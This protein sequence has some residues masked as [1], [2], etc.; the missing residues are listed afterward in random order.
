MLV[1]LGG[2]DHWSPLSTDR[3]DWTEMS[4]WEALGLFILIG[5]LAFAVVAGDGPIVYGVLVV[6]SLA[7]IYD[8][9]TDW[10]QI[11]LI[12]D[13]APETI[14]SV[15]VGRT[16]VHGTCKPLERPLPRP[17]SEEPCVLSYW[18]VE[19]YND[20]W[21][22]LGT[23]VRYVPF[24]V[25]DVTG[26]IEVDPPVDA[27]PKMSEQ[28]STELTVGS[29]VGVLSQEPEPVVAFLQTVDDISV[30]DSGMLSSR[31]LRRYTEAVV[32]PGSEMYVLG[33]A[34]V[35][36][37][38]SGSNP[39]RLV[40]GRDDANGEYI[41]SDRPPEEFVGGD[42]SWALAQIGIGL[43]LLVGIGTLVVLQYGG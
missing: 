10:Q 32:P 12:E 36:E 19:E 24:V 15:A 18:K 39:Q 40:L 5:G 42:R 2:R 37:N 22:T 16:E 23:G 20:G 43:A 9:F 33:G 25:D 3:E 26:T 13:T 27:R 41:I 28:N 6:G 1:L 4:V 21:E 17:F 7:L 31:L 11:R 34:H 35:R 29:G 38:P 30:L 14:Q 8:G